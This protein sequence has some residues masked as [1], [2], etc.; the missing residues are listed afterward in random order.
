MNLKDK[1]DI[2]YSCTHISKCIQ[3]NK[4]IN[5]KKLLLPLSFHR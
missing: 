5:F 4:I 2:G 3:N 1:L